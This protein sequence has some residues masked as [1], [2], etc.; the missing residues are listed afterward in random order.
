MNFCK[1]T[2]KLSAL[3]RLVEMATR[4][5]LIK[6]MIRGYHEYGLIWNNPIVGE[7]LVCERELGNNHDPYCAVAV[8]FQNTG[9]T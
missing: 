7:E 2:R 8:I 3:N 6:L 4:T 9:T 5:F 1:S